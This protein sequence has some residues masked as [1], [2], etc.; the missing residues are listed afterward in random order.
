MVV[1]PSELQDTKALVKKCMSLGQQMVMQQRIASEDSVNKV[2]FDNAMKLAASRGLLEIDAAENRSSFAAEIE[3]S[4]RRLD[5]IAGR[6]QS[7]RR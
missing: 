2:Y 7:R 3:D 5:F 1:D 4:C 6:A